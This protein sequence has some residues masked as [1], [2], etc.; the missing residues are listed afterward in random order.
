MWPRGPSSRPGRRARA[1]PYRTWKRPH[2]GRV[3]PVRR[4]SSCVRLLSSGR[5][6]QC[7]RPAGAMHATDERALAIGSVFQ[8]GYEVLS[9]LGI[10][11]FGSV[12]KA[13]QL[14]TGQDVAI[15]VLRIDPRDGA[16]D[17]E[18]QHARFRREMKLCAG[19]S[20]PNIVRL[21]DSGET[22][23][24][25]LYAVFEYVPG[26]TMRDVLAAEGRLPVE[27]AVRLMSE[28]LDALACAHGHGV[29][30]RDLKPDNI[31]LSKTGARRHA[32]VLDFGLSGF[33]EDVAR[34]ALPRLTQSRELMGTPCYAPP[35]QLRGEPTSTR[36]DLYAW[37]LVLLE[38]LTGEVAVAGG[39][40][41]DV[42]SKQLG[43]DPVAIPVWLRRHP[44][45]RLLEIVTAKQVEKRDVTIPGL[46]EAL[47]AIQL[48]DGPAVEARRPDDLPDGERRQ[49]TVVSCRLSVTPVARRSLDP[50]EVDEALHAQHAVYA[51]LAARAGGQLAGV[52][53]DRVLL[54]FGYPRARE[55]DARRAT[56]TAVAVAKEARRAARRLEA[57]RGLR[58]EV[59][60]GVH[61][62]LVV[63]RGLRQATYQGLYDLVGLTPQ[64]AARL[65]E[66]AA[67]G[68]VLVSGDTYRL[69]RGDVGAEPAG[70][71]QPW[72]DASAVRVFRLVGEMEREPG[73]SWVR[74]TPLVGRTA[75]L[76]ALF[77]VAADLR[78]GR[79]RSVLV[80]GE[81]GMGKSRL[82]R[83][84]RRRVAPE[85]WI[86]AR[87][88][89]ENQAS[90]L[91]PIVDL[92]LGGAPIEGL[93][94][95]HG[96]DL[97]ETM[98][99]FTSLL[100]LPPDPRYPPLALAPDRAKELTIRSL[101]ELFV[102][103]ARERPLVF[104]LEDR[105]E[106][107]TSELQ[108]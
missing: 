87:C 84:L 104:A 59:R 95:R 24:G 92:L 74:E 86:P 44:L 93:L 40:G 42:I 55:D 67:A 58:L 82:V 26:G 108:S 20:H 81:P 66:R 46:L 50:E 18:N 5:V 78:N 13:R 25:M 34:W 51:E 3:R 12:Y 32:L 8:G 21:L 65:D 7:L 83:E 76:R 68:E 9:R 90:P 77:E 57:E 89:A 60:T 103:M 80:T 85:E 63:V 2:T 105:S 28:V 36:S 62:G 35:E 96:F 106:E 107:H 64:L 23:D 79:A 6:A 31:M 10:G 69:L 52:L 11:R 97:A 14:S 47:A 1:S 22:G 70:E 88:V 33:I 37:G 48:G 38:C 16:D 54:V 101:V 4:I 53:A 61:S 73:V 98:P 91:R 99:L 72:P 102:R 19:M 49:L 100:A 45:G 71:I 29:V 15:K 27:E 17:I 39:S 41:A 75:E 94:A 43:P 30:H 56:R